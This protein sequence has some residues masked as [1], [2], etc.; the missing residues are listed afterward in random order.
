MCGSVYLCA[1]PNDKDVIVIDWNPTF[2]P[3]L[4][5]ALLVAAA[6]ASRR[7]YHTVP[8]ALKLCNLWQTVQQQSHSTFV[9]MWL[10]LMMP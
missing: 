4:L 8:Q 9:Y 5:F 3:F 6:A 1:E 2:L 10:L 7:L